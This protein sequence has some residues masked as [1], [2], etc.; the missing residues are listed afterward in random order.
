MKFSKLLNVIGAISNF[1]VIKKN[2]LPTPRALYE[3][4]FAHTTIDIVLDVGAYDG[5]Y[6]RSLIAAGYKN[7]IISFEPCSDSFAKLK[8][9]AKS[10]PKWEVVQKA[11]SNMEGTATLRLANKGVFNSLLYQTENMR[12]SFPHVKFVG[13]ETIKLCRLDYELESRKVHRSSRV[14]LKTDTQGHDREVIEGLGVW[15]NAVDFVI[16]ELSVQPIYKNST[17]HFQMLEILSNNGFDPVA[18]YPITRTPDMR[19]IEYDAVFRRRPIP[20]AR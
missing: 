8:T 5:V 15:I 14:L 1:E 2:R 11:A 19:I 13:V 16:V 18:F 10:V 6:A 20:H 9:L 17:N 4:L 7:E 3:R 12:E